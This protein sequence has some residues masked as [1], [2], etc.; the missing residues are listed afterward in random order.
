MHIKHVT[1]SLLF[2]L[3]LLSQPSL[4]KEQQIRAIGSTAV[5]GFAALVAE[6]FAHETG[7]R[8][9]VIEATGSGGGIN[10]FCSSKARHRG[11]HLVNTSR[12]MSAQEKR[13]CRENG[14]DDVVEIVIGYDGIVISKP[15]ING[16]R[17]ERISTKD[18]FL[19]LAENIRDADGNWVKNPYHNWKQIQPRYPERPILVLGPTH[20]LATREVFEDVV[21]KE[22]CME[23]YGLSSRACRSAGGIRQDKA[24]SEVAEHDNVIVQRLMTNPKAIGILSYGYYCQNTE[25]VPIEIDGLMPTR[26]SIQ[27]RQYKFSRPLLIY[28]RKRDLGSVPGL[29]DYLLSFFSEDAVGPYGYLIQKGFVPLVPEKQRQMMARIK[30]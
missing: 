7:H 13:L 21:I 22:G 29:R 19:A 5:Y 15:I 26:E 1:S 10:L 14:I 2:V 28:V 11:P 8:T 3:L 20:T 4:A 12:P 16:I 30:G 25:V 17:I 6:Y 18:L 27:T 23:L 24:F 9:P